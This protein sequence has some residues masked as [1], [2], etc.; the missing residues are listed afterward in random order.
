MATK[1]DVKQLAKA[2]SDLDMATREFERCKNSL[3]SAEGHF[4]EAERDLSK[5]LEQVRAME[6]ILGVQP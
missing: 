5:A 4:H 2:Y 6:A 3:A 1:E